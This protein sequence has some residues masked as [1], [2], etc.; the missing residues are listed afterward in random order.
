VLVESVQVTRVLV[1]FLGFLKFMEGILMNGSA[2][3]LGDAQED[4]A[5]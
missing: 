1:L 3:N 5:L 2:A 4:L